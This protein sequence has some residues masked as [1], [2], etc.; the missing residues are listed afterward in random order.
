[1][2]TVAAFVASLRP[3]EILPL[4]ASSFSLAA[5]ALV[6][7]MIM[8]IFWSRTTGA[9]AVAGMLAGL[10][11]TVGYMVVNAPA[12]RAVL[13]LPAGQSLWFDIQPVSAAVFGVPLGFAVI[14]V[15]SLLTR[16]RV[17]GA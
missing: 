15:L 9:A 4:V 6:P 1:M 16:R 2:A 10:S 8:G 5:F 3:A 17:A 13:R 14:L 11:V 12:V 7:A